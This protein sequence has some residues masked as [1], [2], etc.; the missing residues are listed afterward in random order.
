[1]RRRRTAAG[2]PQGMHQGTPAGSRWPHQGTPQGTAAATSKKTDIDGHA[3]TIPSRPAVATSGQPQ[4]GIAYPL[5]ALVRRGGQPDCDRWRARWQRKGTL[6]RAIDKVLDAPYGGSRDPQ[7]LS[8]G[9]RNFCQKFQ[10]P[11]PFTLAELRNVSIR[12][13]PAGPNLR[14]LLR[15]SLGSTRSDIHLSTR[16]NVR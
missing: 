16:Q 2:Q 5:A 13:R 14:S 4:H 12:S 11:N 10:V 8:W 3:A 6:S 9:H 1:M 15:R 7:C